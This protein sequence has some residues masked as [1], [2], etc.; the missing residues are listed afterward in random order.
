MGPSILRLLRIANKLIIAGAFVNLLL[1][2]A[3]IPRYGAFGAVLGTVVAEAIIA[4]LFV[5]YDNGY[6]TYELIYQK[7]IKK[8]IAAMIML[9]VIRASTPYLWISWASFLTLVGIG[10]L[11]YIGILVILKDSGLC[12]ILKFIADKLRKII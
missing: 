9:G 3:L 1:N 7:S 4:V 8:L 12:L 6:L 5:K 10:S 11:V 2:L